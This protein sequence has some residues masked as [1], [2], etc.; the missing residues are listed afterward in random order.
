MIFRPLISLLFLNQVSCLSGFKNLERLDLS[1]NNLTSL[2][3][4]SGCVNLKWLSV[5]QNKL[6]N[7]QGIE[8]LTKLTVKDEG[9]C[10]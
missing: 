5:S 1:F 4:L 7:L 6:Q 8:N 3:G 10:L 2:Q 9:S